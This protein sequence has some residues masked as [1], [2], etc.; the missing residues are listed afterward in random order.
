MTQIKSKIN[1]GFTLI[2]VLI[3]VSLLSII[4]ITFAALTTVTIRWSKINE[5]K[6]IAS[7]NIEEIREWLRGQ[8]EAD[9]TGFI[10]K[11]GSWCFNSH[12]YPAGYSNWVLSSDP[13]CDHSLDGIYKRT[14]VLANQDSDRKVLV[15]LHIDWNEG[16]Q[17]FTIDERT[18]FSLHEI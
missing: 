7:H 13:S 8:K 14:V 4:F 3:F 10:G 15:S 9:F 5:H 11:E 17:Y 12:E 18:L 1:L 6:I 16:T 2:E